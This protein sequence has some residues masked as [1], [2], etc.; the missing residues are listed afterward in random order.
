MP[1]RCTREFGV[2]A[3][4]VTV[5]VADSASVAALADAAM[6]T[7]GGIDI[8][9]NNAG[10]YPSAPVLDLDHAEW[11]RVMSVNVRGLLRRL[12]DRSHGMIA[13]DPAA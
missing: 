12:T 7:L 4:G 11:D 8:W 6:A 1:S 13:A 3:H 2:A 9:V 10:I 5:E